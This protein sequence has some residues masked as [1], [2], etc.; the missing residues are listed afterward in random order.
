MMAVEMAQALLM[1]LPSPFAMGNG[2]QDFNTSKYG[3]G[4]DVVA[5]WSAVCL[6][7]LLQR[8]NDKAAGGWKV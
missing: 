3:P 5:P 6:A 7:L 4:E 2:F 1:E 8:C